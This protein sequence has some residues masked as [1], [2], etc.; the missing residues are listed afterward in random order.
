MATFTI[1]NKK[2]IAK[3]VDF[4][5]VCDFED[6]GLAFTDIEKKTT[7]FIRAY[8]AICGGISNESAGKE[9]EKHI[10]NGGTLEDVALA[11]MNE[12]Q[13]SDFFRHSTRNRNRILQRYRQ[14]R[15]KRNKNF[16]RN[17]RK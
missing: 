17:H 2:Y 8:L 11:L 10:M 4:N 5:M 12:V 1:N 9:I 15:K 16:Q 6:M 3:P 14:Q 7:S 13:N